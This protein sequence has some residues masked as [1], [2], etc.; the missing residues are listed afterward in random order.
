[1]SDYGVIKPPAP[2][3]IHPFVSPPKSHRWPARGRKG[4]VALPRR[5][6]SLK[7]LSLVGIALTLNPRHLEKHHWQLA[8]V[9]WHTAKAHEDDTIGR[10]EHSGISPYPNIASEMAALNGYM[11]AGWIHAL[12]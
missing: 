1:M 8:V 2:S 11:E 9:G 12:N 4:V 6:F 5:T 10:R 3:R 7:P